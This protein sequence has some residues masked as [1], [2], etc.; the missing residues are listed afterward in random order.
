[1][2][3]EPPSRLHFCVLERGELGRRGREFRRLTFLQTKVRTAGDIPGRFSFRIA[4]VAKRNGRHREGPIPARCCPY[5]SP[6]Q[7]LRR[8]RTRESTAKA[9][10]IGTPGSGTAVRLTPEKVATFEPIP[11]KAVFTKLLASKRIVMPSA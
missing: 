4:S 5:K 8:R 7:A 1:Q 3:P 6:P 11:S 9:P 10:S 2:L